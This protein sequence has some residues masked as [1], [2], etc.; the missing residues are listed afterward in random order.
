MLSI[1]GGGFMS[2][3]W[4]FGFMFMFSD[5]KLLGLLLLAIGII[6]VIVELFIPGIGF[7]GIAGTIII[8]ISI[9]FTA[10][11]FLEGLIM[12]CVVLGILGLA[13]AYVVHMAKKGKVLK[14]V[15][16]DEK[17]EDSEEA[18][19]ISNEDMEY[20]VGKTG[21]TATQLRPV[22]NVDFDGVKLSVV[23]NGCFIEKDKKVKVIKVDGIRI[24]VEEI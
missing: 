4:S 11:S 21:T 5:L 7:P 22:G 17:S 9:F 8:L 1:L 10:N 14:G 12:L 18:E 15:I 2:M 20:F 23:A 19:S 16:L 6:L 3:I 24:V 13:L